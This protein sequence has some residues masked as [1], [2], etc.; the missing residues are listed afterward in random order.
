[1]EDLVKAFGGIPLEYAI[2]L[3]K[4]EDTCSYCFTDILEVTEEVKEL[5]LSN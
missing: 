3:K 4:I 1:M 2:L 5:K